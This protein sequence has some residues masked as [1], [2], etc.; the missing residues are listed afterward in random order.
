MNCN[1]CLDELATGSLRELTADSAVSRHAANCP[2]CGPLLTA[3][4]DREY[5]AA[6]ILNNLPPMSDPIAV[7]ENAGR[8]AQR[9]RVGSVVVTLMTIALGL[10]I[11]FTADI[12]LP[13]LTRSD[14]DRGLITETIPLSCLS[15]DQAAAIVN[16]YIRSNGTNYYTAQGVKAITIRATPAELARARQVL[17]DFDSGQNSTC[18]KSIRDA[19]EQVQKAFKDINPNV[20]ERP[21]RPER[22]EAVEPTEPIEPALAGS[23]P[24]PTPSGS[25][26]K[27]SKN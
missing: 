5:Q 17:R 27:P 20:N 14:A 19:F 10:T 6:T 1:E 2:D 13:G 15:T 12:M 7:A 11:W 21:E 25:K 3:L 8:L 9:R 18:N 4:R 16:P 22:P 24:A 26:P 23:K